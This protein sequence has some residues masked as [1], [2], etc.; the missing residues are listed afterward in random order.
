MKNKFSIFDIKPEYIFV[1]LAFIFGLQIV[2]VNPPFHSNDEDRHF[3]YA[4][5]F[6]YGKIQQD[7][8]GDST[9]IGTYYPKSL[10]NISKSF[11]GIPYA[12]RKISKAKIK[13]ISITP[14]NE[15][16]T[17]FYTNF[18]RYPS[19]LG[20]IPHII[21]IWVG[22]I[23]NDNPLHIG[24]WAR[25]GGLI[26]YIV[27]MFYVIR[28]LPIFKAFFLLFGLTP[29]V[30]YQMASVTYDFGIVV[31]AF[32]IVAFCLYFTFEEKAFV[33][34]KMILLFTLI[35]LYQNYAK[36]GYYFL[37]VLLFM[38][39][40]RKFKLN[41]NPLFVTIPVVLISILHFKYGSLFWRLFITY[42]KPITIP[43]FQKDFLFN[44]DINLARG[45]SDPIQLLEN[46]WHNLLHFRREWL[47]G[48]IGKFGYSYTEMPMNFYIL[49]GVI[50][51]TVAFL[52]ARDKFVMSL[53]S[54]LVVAATLITTAGFVIIGFYFVGPLGNNLIFG[55]QGRYLIP[56]F[57]LLAL[58]LYNSKFDIS[59]WHKWKYVILTIY[60]SIT[61]F[62]TVDFIDGY[63]WVP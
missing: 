26:F 2:Y 30:L 17:S 61:L 8:N 40:H 55:F 56:F 20:Y 25:I 1:V 35:G 23:V 12:E 39:P 32:S 19:F 28:I 52:E 51:F 62:Y 42:D 4:Y 59:L 21:G 10:L 14:L 27:I 58:L 6:S 31:S 47:A 5:H 53:K 57:P 34:W 43:G 49:H 22:E 38:I 16:D 36:G 11:Q 37:S 29:M 46:I 18:D 45:L 3:Y 41:F 50:L 9:M 63:F 15:Q 48:L 54:K 7:Y 33:D 44:S 13:E 60:I 24:W